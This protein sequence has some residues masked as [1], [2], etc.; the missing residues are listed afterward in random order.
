MHQC[1]QLDDIVRLVAAEIINLERPS[2]VSF[3]CTCSLIEATVMGVLWGS[4]QHDLI[5]LFRCFPSDV[6]EIRESDSGKLYFVWATSSRFRRPIR[7]DSWPFCRLIGFQATP[8][9][10]GMG[11]GQ[12]I[13]QLD[14]YPNHL[15]GFNVPKSFTNGVA[16]IACHQAS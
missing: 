8:I 6:W 10:L 11:T 5:N 4:H 7:A 1:L 12:P 14:A 15:R 3:A 16:G 13:C 9:S 2:A